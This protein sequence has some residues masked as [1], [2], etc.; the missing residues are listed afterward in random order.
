MPFCLHFTS[1]QG[2]TLIVF[3]TIYT[4]RW[5]Y[6][7]YLQNRGLVLYVLPIPSFCVVYRFSA[8][9]NHILIRELYLLVA[10][11]VYISYDSC[12]TGPQSLTQAVRQ[13]FFVP[14]LFYA[15]RSSCPDIIM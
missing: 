9:F 13:S 1:L 7:T 2:S 12:M 5:V 3:I 14:T 4:S 8:G 10:Q 15:S 6:L 11:L